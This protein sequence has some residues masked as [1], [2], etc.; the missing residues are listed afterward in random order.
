[1][2]PWTYTDVTAVTGLLGQ[3]FGAGGGDEVRSSMLL[4]ELRNRL[5]AAA[6]G[7]WRDLRSAD[8]PET[9]MTTGGASRT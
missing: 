6:D 5:G 8:D 1:M 3:A 7:V 2:K 4:A 9:P